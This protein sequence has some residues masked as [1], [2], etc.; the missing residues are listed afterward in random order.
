MVKMSNPALLTMVDMDGQLFAPG[1]ELNIQ[2]LKNMAR[3]ALTFSVCVLCHCTKGN[4]MCYSL[5]YSSLINP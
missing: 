3:L 1:R 4:Q 5:I 2:C